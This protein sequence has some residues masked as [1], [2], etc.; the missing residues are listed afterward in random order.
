[1]SEKRWH[2]LAWS[3]LAGL[4]LAHIAWSLTASVGILDDGIQV[5]SASLL[6]RGQTPNVDF[7]STY[8]PLN[9]YLL[10][11]F[12]RLLGESFVTYRLFHC[13]AATLTLLV[14]WWAARSLGARGRPGLWLALGLCAVRQFEVQ[15]NTGT[16]WTLMAVAALLAARN[17][18]RSRVAIGL[19][20][21]V[22]AAVACAA[23]TRLNLAL[24][25]GAAWFF[26]SLIMLRH[27]P[28]SWRGT[29]IELRDL[30]LSAGAALLAFYLLWGGELRSLLYQVVVVPTRGVVDYAYPPFTFTFSTSTLRQ[31]LLSGVLALPLPLGWLALH[32]HQ[33]GET[34]AARGLASGGLMALIGA[35]SCAYTRPPLLPLVGGVVCLLLAGALFLRAEASRSERLLWLWLAVQ[36]HYP[37][38]RPDGSH[39]FALFPT[40]ALALVASLVNRPLR[41][42]LDVRVLAIVAALVLPSGY[43]LQ[44]TWHGL[45]NAAGS[46]SL[47]PALL[48]QHDA[49]LDQGCGPSC[50]ALSPDFDARR[51]AAFVRAHTAPSE[52]V[53]SGSQRHFSTYCN[54]VHLYWLL[55]RKIGTRY[56]LMMLGVST[57][58]PD[59]QQL[60]ADLETRHVNW[61]VLWRGQPL[62][63]KALLGQSL[64]DTYLRERFTVRQ[65]FGDYAVLQ[66][67]TPL[68]R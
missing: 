64:V 6:L 5:A 26:E 61:A 52:A 29:M 15:S 59:E 56:L 39:Y 38:S 11:L 62:H 55:R 42:A 10:G 3:L 34:R 16:M 66:R 41:T 24:Y 43:G 20:A 32:K 2:W 12:F 35:L 19:R 49:P 4:W 40:I 31:V 58:K 57:P 17:E 23:A 46:L 53:L 67:K 47:V 18:P 25:F 33:R 14:M 21:I 36:M 28:S 22:G 44:Q 48:A 37:L 1:M 8:P 13:V 45:K 68:P 50:S 27:Q 51:A 65:T 63:T 30:A 9:A 7:F 60:I 54:D